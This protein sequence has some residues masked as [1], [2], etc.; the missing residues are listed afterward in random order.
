MRAPDIDLVEFSK[1]NLTME[2]KLRRVREY[3]FRCWIGQ[4]LIRLGAWVIPCACQV[5]IEEE[6][7]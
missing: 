4:M 2:V 1:Y 6:E 7:K 3:K 5:T